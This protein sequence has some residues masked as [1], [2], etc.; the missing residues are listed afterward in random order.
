MIIFSSLLS[1]IDLYL[2][3]FK[4]NKMETNN[5]HVCPWW[6]GYMLLI[7]LRKLGQ[8]PEKIL[9]PHISKGM[10]ILDYGSAMG[11]FS[12]PLAKITGEH[13][14]V[15]CVDIQK[16]MLEKL[17]KRAERAGVKE[18][19]KPRLVGKDFSTEELKEKIDFTMLFAVVHEVPDKINLFADL[20]KMAKSGSKVL[21]AEPKG[22]VTADEFEKSID[23]AVKSGFKVIDEKPMKKGLSVFLMK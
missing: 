6:M 10:N 16:K 1:H 15:Y 4:T 3:L 22:H 13:G 17:Q 20:Y 14:N 12:L 21:F 9:T 23:I 18:I 2:Q 5:K 8:S 7:P 19:I 11:Y